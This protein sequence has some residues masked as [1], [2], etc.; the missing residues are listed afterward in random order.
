MVN[1]MSHFET[2]G[3]EIL[4]A[5][6]R[7]DM[8][9]LGAGTGGTLSGVGLRLKQKYPDCIIVAAEPDGSTL[10]DPCADEHPFLVRICYVLI[11]K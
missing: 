6:D 8:I 4:C 9:V 3:T 10:F 1:P 2:T 5:L 7:V 11:R